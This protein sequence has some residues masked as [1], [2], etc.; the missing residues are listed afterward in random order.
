[1]TLIKKAFLGKEDFVSWIGLENAHD[2]AL[3]HNYW[4]R[5]QWSD[6][7]GELDLKTSEMRT[8]L[9]DIQPP[10]RGYLNGG[11]ILSRDSIA[12]INSN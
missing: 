4:S 8:S 11:S 1:M 10:H 3:P 5:Q 6:V 9:G 7:L 12:A 2:V